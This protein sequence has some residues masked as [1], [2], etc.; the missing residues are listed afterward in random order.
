MAADEEAYL[1][2][3]ILRLVEGPWP[4]DPVVG[5][6]DPVSCPRLIAADVSVHCARVACGRA[7]RAALMHLF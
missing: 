4:D 1:D 7:A 6:K 5:W 2:A 3:A